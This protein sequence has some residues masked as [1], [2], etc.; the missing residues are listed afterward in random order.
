M[1]IPVIW[2]SNHDD[3]LCRGNW[4]HGMLEALFDRSLWRV[5]GGFTFEHHECPQGRPWPRAEGAVV[6][7]SGRNHA[8]DRDVRWLNQ[9]LRAFPWVLLVT[10]GDEE[11]SFPWPAMKH[12]RMVVWGMGAKPGSEG[13]DFPLGSG[14]PPWFRGALPAE[15][16]EKHLEFVFAGQVTHERRF[17]AAQQMRD[18]TGPCARLETEAF[19][20]G[21]PPAEYAD[22]MARGMVAPCPSG[23]ESPD[24]FRLYE[25]LEAG[26][27]PLADAVTP[28]GPEPGYWTYVLGESP[29]FPEVS[30]WASF[31]ALMAD[32]LAGWP[33]NATRIHAWWGR[34]KRRLAWRLHDDLCGLV[35]SSPAA[36]PD[37]EI[38]VV[39]STSPAPLHPSPEH[40]AETLAS[41]RERLGHAEIVVAADGV[42]PEQA[43]L[44]D[45][46]REYL[47]RVVWASHHEWSNVIVLPRAAWG[48][49]AN[50]VR[51]ALELVRTPLV[52]LVEHDT[53]LCGEQIDWAACTEALH[54]GALNVVRFHH[55]AAV[56]PEHAHLMLDDPLTVGGQTFLRTVQWSQRPH[57]APTW[58]YE[59]MLGRHFTK[60]SR[61]F[62]ED[63]VHGI[64]QSD[65]LDRGAPGWERWRLGLYADETGGIG[66]KR[67]THLDSRGSEPK[68]SQRFRYPGKV[69]PGAPKPTP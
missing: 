4:D 62:I 40:L 50:T 52:L 64:I 30:D 8:N 61:S 35:G 34:W 1:V 41:I 31:P 49:Q 59:D 63:V 44:A 22:V 57:L 51:D 26:C 56:L 47:R 16:P 5:P 6:V 65:W 66:I 38:T 15:P 17:L 29:P 39:V 21:L 10:A 58:W 12:P 32:A 3:V 53:P 28:H 68:H 37:E 55:E 54:S 25:A 45:A 69:P 67:S 42:R 23:P 48:H 24:S 11:A 60:Q 9:Q 43:H 19:T 14:W 46:Y 20:T 18:W 27:I 33:E 2:A 36:P 13:V 7:V